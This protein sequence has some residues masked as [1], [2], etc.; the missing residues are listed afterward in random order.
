[1]AGEEV[2]LTT[3][4]VYALAGNIVLDPRPTPYAATDQFTSPDPLNLNANNSH[5]SFVR[6]LSIRPKSPNVASG[7][8]YTPP[9]DSLR[10]FDP[11]SLLPE[12]EG[13]PVPKQ[14]LIRY[15]KWPPPPLFLHD[16]T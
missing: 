9:L 3:E 16:S 7:L 13:E 6:T 1:M 4:S 10:I 14:L 12:M 2:I 15:C 5:S 8:Y 11:F